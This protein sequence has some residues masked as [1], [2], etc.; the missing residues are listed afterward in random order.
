MNDACEK[1]ICFYRVN[2][3]YGCFSNFA[4]YPI[5]I[6]G[7]RW[8]TSEHFFQGQKFAGTPSEDVIRNLESPMEAAKRGRDRSLPLRKDWEEVKDDL[9]RQAVG[10]KFRQH[11]ELREVL[12]ST[13]N[14]VL[15]EHTKND[16]YWAD[17]G[18]GSGKNM[19]GIILMELRSELQSQGTL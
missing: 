15:I 14:A 13:G 19:L 12:L 7:K 11:A 8:P 1:I 18:D 6:D 9:M 16:S 4:P 10:E 2:D 17:G 3:A 5:V